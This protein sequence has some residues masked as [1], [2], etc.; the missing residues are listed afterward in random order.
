MTS[1]LFSLIR[2]IAKRNGSAEYYMLSTFE[3]V[4]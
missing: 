2:K 4:I 3:F 1:K